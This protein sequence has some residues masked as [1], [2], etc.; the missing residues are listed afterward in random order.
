MTNSKI[1]ITKYGILDFTI[2]KT[3]L[4]GVINLSPD[5]QQKHTIAHNAQ[6]ALTMAQK[7]REWGAS[8]ID[9]GA[10]SSHYDNKLLTP[11]EEIDRLL[12]AL[13]LLAENNFIVSVDTWKPEVAQAALENGASIINDTGG[14][15]KPKMIEIV[16][17]YNCPVIP[18][19]VE[20][21]NPLEVGELKIEENKALKTL[22]VLKERFNLFHQQGINQLILDPGIAINY[23]VD[24]EAYTKQQLEVIRDTKLFKEL[25]YPVLIP[26]PRKKPSFNWVIAYITLAIEYKAD[27]IRVH[28]VEAAGDLVKLLR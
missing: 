10:Q 1:I 23:K 16:K 9:L 18:V 22:E 7:Y 15:T 3:H 20:A 26:I 21:K 25:N 27:L 11:Q 6:E 14:L 28:D 5:S 2:D 17:Q 24:Y 12:P 4:M 8:L 13:K 19:Y